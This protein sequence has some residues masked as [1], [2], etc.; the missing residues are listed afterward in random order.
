MPLDSTYE[1]INIVLP[2]FVIIATGYFFGTVKKID[3]AS[4]NEVILYISV[5]CL[6]ISSLSKFPIE[7]GLTLKIF[8]FVSAVVTVCMLS[9]I[10]LTKLLNLP[11]R[12]YIPTLMFANTGNMGLPLV[13]FAFGQQGFNLGILYMIGTTVLHYTIGIVI[14]NSYKKPFELFRLPLVYSA[15][16][17]ILISL[18]EIELPVA[19]GRSVELLGDIAIPAMIFSL[20]YKLSELKLTKMGTSF[21]FGT[22]RI[23]IGFIAGL[24]LVDLFGLSGTA[25][26]V[27]ILQ[28]SMPPAVFNFVLAEKYNQDSETVASIIMAGT[29]ASLAIIPFVISYLLMI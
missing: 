1:I 19:L 2:V 26:K 27:V 16:I 25:A 24:L 15:V 3:L 12:V 4:I 13:L 28:A 7:M 18:Y 21:L 11:Y 14:L 17:A 9:G 23:A 8:L 10:A 22:M 29:L 5:P 6:I 20:G